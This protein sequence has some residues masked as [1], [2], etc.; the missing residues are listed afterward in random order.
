MVVAE[1]IQ[2]GV[3][4]KSYFALAAVARLAALVGPCVPVGL[5]VRNTGALRFLSSL[6]LRLSRCR[7]ERDER[8]TNGALHGVLGR[9]VEGDPIDHGADDDAAPHEHTDG[10]ADVLVIPAEAINPANDEGVAATEQV[11]QSAPLRS[12]AELRAHAGYSSVRYDLV[13]LETRLLGLGPLVFEGLFCAADARVQDGG[14]CGAHESVEVASADKASVD[15]RQLLR[16]QKTSESTETVRAYP[17]G[18]AQPF[19]L[20]QTTGRKTS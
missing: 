16:T 17:F 5:R 2:C 15:S 11:E 7:H 4:A 6:S 3:P 9:A 18:L 19:G 10:L 12:F 13:E 14:H 8:V 20:V 1:F